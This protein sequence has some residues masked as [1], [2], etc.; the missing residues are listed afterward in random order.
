MLRRYPISILTGSIKRGQG[1]S[2]QVEDFN[3]NERFNG[4]TV[5][6]DACVIKIRDKFKFDNNCKPIK[7][8]STSISSYI[9]KEAMVSG[10]GR[11]S[12]SS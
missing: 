7:L 8:A 1:T 9:D 11:T 4:R 3:C 2:Y 12:V 6:Y 5:D 10:Y